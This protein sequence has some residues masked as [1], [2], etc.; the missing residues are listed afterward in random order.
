M[1]RVQGVLRAVLGLIAG[2]F[3]HL[4]HWSTSHAAH[5]L[6]SRMVLGGRPCQPVR[7]TFLDFTTTCFS[8]PLKHPPTCR[9]LLD[10]CHVVLG[11]FL[12]LIYALEGNMVTLQA[13]GCCHLRVVLGRT[14]VRCLVRLFKRKSQAGNL[15]LGLLICHIPRLPAHLPAPQVC[16]RHIG[17]LSECGVRL[18]AAF[19]ALSTLIRPPKSK[20]KKW[21]QVWKKGKKSKKSRK[22]RKAAAAGGG[23]GSANGRGS[24]AAD[25]AAATAAAL[26]QEQQRRVRDK[27]AAAAAADGQQARHAGSDSEGDDPFAD[28][29]D[30]PTGEQNPP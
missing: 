4:A 22:A 1:K 27:A 5:S 28:L 13:S 12:S 9:M 16:Q 29:A 21:W 3:W 15:L 6:H 7:L 17:D 2:G 10:S 8:N 26:E 25:A 20:K 11:I 14:S 24:A 30:G 18:S 23:G 19:T